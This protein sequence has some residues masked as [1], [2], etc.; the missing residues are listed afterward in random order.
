MKNEKPILLPQE[1]EGDYNFNCRSLATKTFMDEFGDDALYLTV[2]SKKMILQLEKPDYLQ[3]FI[4]KGIK[5][6]CI[7][8]FQKGHEYDCE[9]YITFLLPSD[10]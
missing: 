2:I 5:Y 10:Y 3:V 8:Q 9:P 7:G 1:C 6:Y 4:Y